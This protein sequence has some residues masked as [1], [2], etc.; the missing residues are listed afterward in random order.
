MV[1]SISFINSAL[2]LLFINLL[3]KCHYPPR[4]SEKIC[5]KEAAEFFNIYI[6]KSLSLTIKTLYN[7][8]CFLCWFLFFNHWSLLKEGALI[9]YLI[10]FKPRRKLFENCL[11]FEWKDPIVNRLYSYDKWIDLMHLQFYI[12]LRETKRRFKRSDEK[13]FTRYFRYSCLVVK[14]IKLYAIKT[15]L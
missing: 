15:I 13:E 10:R 12:R 2:R 3:F 5:E 9:L 8:W 4:S 6:L 7:S 14:K 1:W 11:S